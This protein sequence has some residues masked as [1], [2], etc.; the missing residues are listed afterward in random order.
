M[1]DYRLSALEL[2]LRIHH[3]DNLDEILATAERFHEFMMRPRVPVDQNPVPTPTPA[4]VP[5]QAQPTPTP[6]PTLAPAEPVPPPTLNPQPVTPDTIQ[7]NVVPIPD[8]PSM[9]PVI[10]ADPN[11][12]APATS[13]NVPVSNT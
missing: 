12:P 9:S 3:N 7:A 8:V 1:P 2:S 6:I 10:P 5:V 11:A 13:P 4:P